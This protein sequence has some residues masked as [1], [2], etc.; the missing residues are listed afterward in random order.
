MS[1]DFRKMHHLF[2]QIT[3]SININDFMHFNSNFSKKKYVFETFTETDSIFKRKH[4]RPI[5]CGKK[6]SPFSPPA[7]SNGFC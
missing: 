7:I 4:M 5:I 6:S 3:T 2:D 1:H